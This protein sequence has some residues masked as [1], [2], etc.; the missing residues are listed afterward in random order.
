MKKASKQ[1]RPEEEARSKTKRKRATLHGKD[2][3]SFPIT[4]HFAIEIL[5]APSFA[6]I[7]DSKKRLID[8]IWQKEQKRRGGKLYEGRI[9]SA[10]SKTHEKLTGYFVPYKYFL[11]Q[12]CDPS[13]KPDLKIVPVSLSG[14]TVIGDN[15][16]I[17]KRA[18]WVAEYP[19][20]Y[21]LAPSGGVQPPEEGEAVDLKQQLLGELNDEICIGAKMVKGVKFFALVHDLKADS[22]EIC[23]EI[24]VKPYAILSSSPEYQQVMSLPKSEIES[25]VNAHALEFVPLSV[26]LLK[27]RK[28]LPKNAK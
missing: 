14:L 16:I 26:L 15:L 20:F 12:L 3:Q 23:A 10:L 22:L 5:E 2:Y 6:E 7:S 17:A 27:L 4:S 11:A 19:E 18:D 13:L 25:F 24:K 8:T 21:E 9:L 28:L 1:V